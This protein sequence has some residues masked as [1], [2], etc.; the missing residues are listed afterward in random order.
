MQILQAS[1]NQLPI[2][3][4]LAYKIWPNAYAEIL[5][6]AQLDFML[7]NFY[8][9]DS[10]ENQLEN[11]HIFLLAED[12]GVYY[13]FASYEINCK[14]QGKTKLHK[15]YVLPNTQK[16]GVGKM[17]LESVEKAAQKALNKYLFLNV[18]KY[19]NAKNFYEKFEFKII[20]EE[21]I[22][23]GQGYVMDDYVMEKS[24]LF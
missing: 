16:N 22:D 19:N 7:E 18:N 21:M 14:E 6:E 2:I 23:I 10:L 15:I 9:I 3:Q 20:K 24:I 12:D 1:K 8:S 4:D 5:A 11:N 13:G 17:L